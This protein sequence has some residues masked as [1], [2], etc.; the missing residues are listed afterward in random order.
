MK[1]YHAFCIRVKNKL[2]IAF[3]KIWLLNTSAS[4]HFTPFESKIVDITLSYYGW[5]KTKHTIYDWLE[6]YSN[7]IWNH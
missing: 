3:I 7:W 4:T 5:V 1:K 6:Y 2:I